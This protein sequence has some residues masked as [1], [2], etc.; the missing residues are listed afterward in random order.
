MNRMI[1]A[2]LVTQVSRNAIIKLAPGNPP[3]S[4]VRYSGL[5][6]CHAASVHSTSMRDLR[7]SYALSE[8]S[9]IIKLTTLHLG[10]IAGG[11]DTIVTLMCDT[12]KSEGGTRL[13]L[14]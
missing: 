11:A 14:A 9:A 3:C 2:G 7:Q 4:K 6:N 12:L 8:L 5:L 10:S 1:G 13:P